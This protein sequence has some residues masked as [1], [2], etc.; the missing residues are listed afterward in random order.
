MREYSPLKLSLLKEGAR[1]AEPMAPPPTTTVSRRS[2]MGS[3]WVTGLKP[4][5]AGSKPG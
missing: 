4:G 1:V 5:E 3:V 2:A